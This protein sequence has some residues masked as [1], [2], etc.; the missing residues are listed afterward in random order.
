MTDTPALTPA[1]RTQH[2]DP[3]ATDHV[4]LRTLAGSGVHGMALDGTDD[5]DEMGVYVPCPETILGT[6]HVPE[7]FTARTQP[8]GHPSGPDD[9][10]LNLYSLRKYVRM[11]LEG[12]PT[13]LLPLFAPGPDVLHVTPLGRELRAMRSMFASRRGGRRFLGYLDAQRDRLTGGGKRNRVPN[14]PHL[15]ERYGYDVKYASHALRLGHQGVEFVT[16]GRL[17]LPL[18]DGQR[19]RCVAV[20]RG[21]VPYETALEWVDQTRS[22]LAGLLDSPLAVPDSPDVPGI[23]AWCADAHRRYWEA[24]NG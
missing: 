11:C 21:E 5:R 16:T 7:H 12:H 4:I 10:D 8:E 22:T 9:V 20:K 19:E 14:R 13:L 1:W 23:D 3:D 6:R 2:G 18:A 15:V 17:T 24:T